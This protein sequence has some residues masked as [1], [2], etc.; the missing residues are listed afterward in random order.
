MFKLGNILCN[1]RKQ[2][3]KRQDLGQCLFQVLEAAPP[4]AC[5]QEPAAKLCSIWV[6]HL[7]FLQRLDCQM[8]SFAFQSSGVLQ[9]AVSERH[10]LANCRSKKPKKQTNKKTNKKTKTKTKKPPENRWFTLL[11]LGFA[12]QNCG[13]TLMLQEELKNYS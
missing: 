3:Y 7:V 10:R 1:S 4:S 9:A 12:S 2:T 6:I 5:V 11:K 13:C 8:L